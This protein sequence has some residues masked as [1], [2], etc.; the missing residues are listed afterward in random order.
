MIKRTIYIG[1][2]RHLRTE[3]EQLILIDKNEGIT[4][5]VPIEDIGYLILDSFNTSITSRAMQKLIENDCVLLLCSS[6]HLPVA[7]MLSLDGHY[8]QTQRLIAQTELGQPARKQLWKQI[9]VAKIKNQFNLLE[10][11]AYDNRELKSAFEKV[12]S[13]DTTNREGY[14]AR[15]YWKR[16]FGNETFRRDREGDIPNPFLNYGYAILRAVVA[17]SLVSAGLNPSLGLFHKNKYNAYFLAD[18]LMEPYRPFI[19]EI[20][21]SIFLS[22]EFSGEMIMSKE[23]KKL[24]L[25]IPNI[26]VRLDGKNHVLQIAVQTTCNSLASYYMGEKIKLKLPEL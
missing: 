25:D 14:A 7:M 21:R 22:S 8:S 24:L 5:S 26:D 2:D 11:Y 12:Q 17:R 1:S 18:D 23:I 15:I 20:V 13:G 19:D 6:N 4:D 9:V 16:I 3:N 10:K